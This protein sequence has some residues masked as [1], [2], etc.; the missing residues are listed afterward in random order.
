MRVAGHGLR[1]EGRP[2]TAPGCAECI[3]IMG[4]D[5]PRPIYRLLYGGFWEKRGEGHG[6]CSCGALSPHVGSTAQRQRWHKE[7]KEQE[8]AND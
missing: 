6:L 1:S 2:Y 5:E 4:K 8:I 3:A 7:H